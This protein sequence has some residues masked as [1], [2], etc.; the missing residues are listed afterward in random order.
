MTN[1]TTV[2]VKKT[3]SEMKNNK[4]PREDGVVIEAIKIGEHLLI[5]I[6][7]NYYIA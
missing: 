7:K 1:I 4:T 2:E 3:I 5:E 6:T